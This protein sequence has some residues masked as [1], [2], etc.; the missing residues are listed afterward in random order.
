MHCAKLFEIASKEESDVFKQM[1]KDTKKQA[2]CPF[3]RMS[4]RATGYRLSNTFQAG[5]YRVDPSHR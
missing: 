2:R 3:L 4:L 5:L 1:D